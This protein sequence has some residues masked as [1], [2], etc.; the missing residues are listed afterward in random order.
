MRCCSYNLGLIILVMFGNFANFATR[1]INPKLYSPSH[2]YLY[3]YNI[4]CKKKT[5]QKIINL[6]QCI[7][8]CFA[9][10]IV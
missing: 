7:E 9:A 8:Q 4:K 2:D 5:R 3:K 10:H 6:L 1:T